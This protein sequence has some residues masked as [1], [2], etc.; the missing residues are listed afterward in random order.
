M[1]VSWVNKI[2]QDALEKFC[3]VTGSRY[4]LL[5]YIW[6]DFNVLSCTFIDF[7]EQKSFLA[8]FARYG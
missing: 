8:D 2:H 3:I 7:F 1:E 6:G 5:I 4:T